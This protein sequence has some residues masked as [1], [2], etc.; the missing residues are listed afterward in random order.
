MIA[1][2][3]S[4]FRNNLKKYLDAVE[5]ND[6]TL[7]ITRSRGRGAVLISLAEYNSLKE[8]LHI[9]GSEANARQIW[10][11]QKEFEEGKFIEFKLPEEDEEE[12]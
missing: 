8:T 4:E 12:N 10:Q 6:D 2:N 7:I 9:L 11:S 1:T 5:E 3:F